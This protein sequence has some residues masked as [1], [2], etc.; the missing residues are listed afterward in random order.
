[1]TAGITRRDFLGGTLIASG[2]ALL[3]PAP[4]SWLGPDWD[5]DGGV[6]EYRSSHGNTTA[7]MASAHALRDGA[8]DALPADTVETG[9]TFDLVVVGGG[10]SGLAAALAFRQQ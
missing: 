1:M 2:D 5:G 10:L 3:A 4:S 9:E 6:G 7:W 8:Y